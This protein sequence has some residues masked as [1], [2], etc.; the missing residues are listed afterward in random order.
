MCFYLSNS[1]QQRLTWQLYTYP[2]PK[3]QLNKLLKKTVIVSYSI[4]ISQLFFSPK[5][6]QPISG[7][8][9]LLL[10]AR[11]RGLL[12]H[13][14]GHGGVRIAGDGP[15]GPPARAG[16]SGRRVP[17]KKTVEDGKKNKGSIKS[18]IFDD[19]WWLFLKTSL[20]FTF[21]EGVWYLNIVVVS[22]KL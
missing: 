10:A 19:V 1:K 8:T 6:L 11:R 17:Q 18:L 21:F 15:P 12:G 4:H 3:K 7:L 14:H 2:V 5:H 22:F 20:G 16:P 13:R 9:H